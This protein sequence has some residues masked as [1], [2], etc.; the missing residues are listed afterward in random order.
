MTA[1]TLT[2]DW[3]R[4]PARAMLKATGLTDADLAK[5]LVGIANTWTEATPCN[6]HLRR[7]AERVK[8]G[9]RRAGGTPIEFNTICVSDGIAMGT[10]G[11]RASLVSREVIADSIELVVTGHEF[12]A[13][14]AL[15]GCDKTIPGTLM[16]LARLNV[17]GLMLYG[18]SIMPGRVNG[19]DVT[20]Q[21][22]FEAVGACAAG[23]IS[24]A[25]LKQVEDHACPGAGACGGQFTAN[26]MAL[27]ATALGLS[28]MGMNDIPA[29]H[30]QKDVAAVRIGE[31][32]VECLRAGRRPRDFI[33]P[34]SLA[35]AVAVVAASGGSTNAIL[36]LLA[37]AHEACVSMVLDDFDRIAAA[38][39]IVCDL[40]PGGRYVAHDFHA[41]G[42]SPVL[43]QRLAEAGVLKD[44][45][46]VDGRQLFATFALERETLGQKVVRRLDDVVSSRGGFAVVRGNIAPEGA[47]VKLAGHGRTRFVGPARV[48][49]GEVAAFAAVEQ[50]MLQAGDVVV[51]RHVGPRGAPGM[52]EMLKVTAAIVGAGLGDRVALITDGRFSGATHG[53]MVGHVAPEA[54]TGGAIGRLRDGDVVVIDVDRR[55]IMTEAPLQEREPSRNPCAAPTGVFAK[56]AAMV[57]S[58]AFGAVTSVRTEHP[59]YQEALT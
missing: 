5:P 50:G 23:K 53:F 54:S 42:G 46:T 13:V 31:L 27:A 12:A 45:P 8:E 4:A 24:R 7:L 9:V 32:A 1:D 11:M 49:D 59:N 29:T 26:T 15:S 41:A 19:R 30:P 58:A 36:H 43:C 37:I 56:Y 48:F 40:K 35:N 47:I 55:E 44:A 3:T 33:T 22:V 16:A 20:I 28:P 18:G 25:E 21:D 14:V 51:I 57:G 34:V 38:T 17:P 10:P 6:F 52:P 39:P 2:G